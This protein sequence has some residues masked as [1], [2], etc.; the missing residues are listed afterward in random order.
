[1]NSVGR[2][3]RRALAPGSGQTVITVNDIE[4]PRRNLRQDNGAGQIRHKNC[5]FIQMTPIAV[6]GKF[7]DL[8]LYERKA[9]R[10]LLGEGQKPRDIEFEDPV[11]VRLISGLRNTRL[12]S[13]IPS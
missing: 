13:L 11:G 1:L 5:H 3:R 7:A 12:K 10:V 2:K 9:I 6:I 4:M 8:H